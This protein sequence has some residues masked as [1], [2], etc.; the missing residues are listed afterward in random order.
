IYRTSPRALAS[1]PHSVQ[2]LRGYWDSLA[3]RGRAH[4]TRFDLAMAAG[5]AILL[6]AFGIGRRRALGALSGGGR[7][8]CLDQARLRRLARI[9]VRLVLLAEQPVLSAQPP[10]GR[11]EHGWFGAGA[12]R[13]QILRDRDFAGDPVDR[14]AH[15]P[16]RDGRGQVDQ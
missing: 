14:A 5:S 10:A 9:S 3:R 1:R 16:V 7:N 11:R 2:S 12:Y 6:R 13:E 4:R 8:L 15:A